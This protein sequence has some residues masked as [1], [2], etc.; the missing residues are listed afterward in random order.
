MIIF[1]QGWSDRKDGPGHRRIFYLKG[2]NLRCRWCASPESIDARPQL[3]FYADRITPDEPAEMACPYHAITGTCLDRRICANCLDTPCRQLHHPALEYVG[4]KRSPEEIATEC[5]RFARAW[6]DFGGVTFGGGEPTLQ[7]TEL[8]E[9]LDLLRASGI[10]TTIE[11]NASTQT[12]QEV[13]QHV[14]FLISDLK[15]GTEQTMRHCTGGNLADVIANLHYAASHHPSLLVRI[16]VITTQNDSPAELQA[17]ADRLKSLHE[18]RKQSFGQPL[19]VEI[20]RLHHFGEPK[21]KALG[22]PYELAGIEPPSD[23]L[24]SSFQH[25]LAAGGLDIIN[26]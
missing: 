5:R 12:Y 1:S 16:P 26:N 18:T 20:L 17:I 7:S 22:L 24:I 3:L 21:Y 15:A 4:I 9:C 19:Q 14:D 2:C 8:I 10:N 11:S 25:E 6:T 23:S 13:I